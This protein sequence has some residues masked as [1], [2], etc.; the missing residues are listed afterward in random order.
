MAS[1]VSRNSK[2]YG[3]AMRF[4]ELAGS[5]FIFT[6]K[7]PLF[8]GRQVLKWISGYDGMRFTEDEAIGWGT[9]F[10]NELAHDRRDRNL[11]ENKDAFFDVPIFNA[12]RDAALD[13]EFYKISSKVFNDYAKT[14]NLPRVGYIPY[15]VNNEKD[16]L[17]KK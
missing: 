5:A 3:T 10:M 15:Y 2:Y 6:K 12:D 8:I 4:G 13:E 7:I 16:K 9:K 1:V 17:T 14:M 11:E